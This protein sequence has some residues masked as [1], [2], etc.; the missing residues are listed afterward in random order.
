EAEV[1][2][3]VSVKVAKAETSEIAA[4]VVAVGTV[5]PKEKAE[6]AAK[7][8]AQIKSMALLKNKLV[9]AGEVIAVL[10]S[11]D[12]QAQRAE[13]LAAVNEAKAN[14]RQVVTGTIPQTDAEDQ[15]ALRDAT[16]KVANTRA[17]YER[18]KTLF[19]KGGISQKEL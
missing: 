1:T 13:A 16:A 4:E 18:R 8:S 11:K 10:E 2:P 6:V 7:I 12:L 19:E 14:E 5:W 17:T 9:K 3:V 15:K